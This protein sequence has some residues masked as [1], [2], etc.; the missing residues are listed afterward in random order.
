VTPPLVPTAVSVL[1]LSPWAAG[2][3]TVNAP[4]VS[5]AASAA[6]RHLLLPLLRLVFMLGP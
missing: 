5:S 3:D 1:A 2:D 6:V 4:V